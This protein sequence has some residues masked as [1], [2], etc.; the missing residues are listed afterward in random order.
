[1]RMQMNWLGR[2]SLERVLDQPSLLAVLIPS[3]KNV[4][5]VI[6][7]EFQLVSLLGFKAVA[8]ALP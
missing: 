5:V 1:M 2:T 7:E 3:S 8:A 4:H 6:K